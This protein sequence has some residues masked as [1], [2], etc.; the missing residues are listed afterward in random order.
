[1]AWAAVLSAHQESQAAVQLVEQLLLAG[2][3]KDAVI[4]TVNTMLQLRSQESFATLDVLIVDAE[5]GGRI[6]KIGAAQA[7]YGRK[8]KCRK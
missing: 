4:R 2:F 5:K 3:Q 6:F 1:M 7:I 8:E